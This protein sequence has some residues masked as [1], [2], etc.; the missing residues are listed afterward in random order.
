M[1]YDS[2]SNYDGYDPPSTP[3]FLA[4]L[5]GIGGTAGAYSSQFSLAPPS[6]AITKAQARESKMQAYLRT[7]PEPKPSSSLPVDHD[8]FQQLGGQHDEG[9]G[10]RLGQFRP[11]KNI[12]I[13]DRNS[14]ALSFP[15]EVA[16]MEFEA[17]P[18]PDAS[19]DNA[20]SSVGECMESLDPP[21]IPSSFASQDNTATRPPLVSTNEKKSSSKTSR[22]ATK[23]VKAPEQ[24]IEI[25]SVKAVENDFGMTD[26]SMDTLPAMNVLRHSAKLAKLKGSKSALLPKSSRGNRPTTIT[27]AGDS[28]ST[29]SS[30]GQLTNT[31]GRQILRMDVYEASKAGK[32]APLPDSDQT[33]ADLDERTSVSSA[34]SSVRWLSDNIGT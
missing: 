2:S 7:F 31:A 22:D 26:E 24:D 4:P 1:S 33:T 17:T 13:N 20:S 3:S 11:D 8:E 34:K 14:G 27:G 16:A 6:Y 32:P 10:K 21:C 25:G 30:S 15:V 29:I 18:Q 5:M 19:T 23:A 12:D 9:P 28:A